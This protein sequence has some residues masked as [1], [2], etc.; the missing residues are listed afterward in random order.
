MSKLIGTDPNQVPSNAD[1]GTAAFMDATDFL[2]SRGSSLSAVNTVIP[3]TAVDVFV[4][5]TSR[6]SDGGAWRKRTKNTS[7]YNERLNTTTR[8]SR[9]EFPA[10]AVIVAE[11]NQVTIYDGDD[12]DMPMWMVFE[13]GA[14]TIPWTSTV[15][16]V[17]FLNGLFCI[18]CNGREVEANFISEDITLR[19]ATY[20]YAYLVNIKGRNDV[21]S[22][23]P[24]LS[25]TKNIINSTVNDLAMTVLPNAPIDSATG[26]PVPTIAVATAGGVSVI[27]DTGSVYDI[28]NSSSTYTASYHVSF[29]SKNNLWFHQGKT[30]LSYHGWVYVYSMPLSGDTAISIN[31][32]VATGQNPIALFQR[33]GSGGGSIEFNLTGGDSLIANT[34]IGNDKG[35]GV[36]DLNTE[37]HNASMAFQSTSDFNTGWQVGDIKLATL[38]DTDDTDIVSTNLVTGDNSTFTGGLGDWYDNSYAGNGSVLTNTGGHLTMNTNGTYQQAFVT[39]TNV[40]EIGKRYVFSWDQIAQGSGNFR[41]FMYTDTLTVPQGS[42]GTFGMTFVATGV[43]L[44]MKFKRTATSGNC[45][46]DNI[47]VSLAEADRSV[48]GNGLQVF[49]TVTKNPVAT[50]ADLMAYSG[51]STT[52]SKVNYLR[53]PYASALDFDTSFCFM[54]WIKIDGAV[55]TQDQHFFDMINDDNGNRVNVFYQHST[56]NF[57]MAPGNGGSNIGSAAVQ[58]GQW[59]HVVALANTATTDIYVNGELSGTGAGGFNHTWPNGYVTLGTRFAEY[60]SSAYGLN[61]SM[62]LIR[63]SKSTPS[64]EQ[65]KKIYND[66]KHLFQE[67]AKATLYGSSDAV[68]ALAYDDS[69][70]LLHV[71]TSN[72]RSDFQG[73][74][75][76]NN[77][78]RA[79][80]A[81]ISAADGFIIEE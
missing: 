45:Q 5:D 51:F 4:Y 32:Q 29:D 81:V 36:F 21:P 19:D 61:G 55:G 35:I 20:W 10:V 62:A 67:N 48:N 33:I 64:S 72:G 54:G 25:T 76:V 77:T 31:S 1:L 71:G 34:A 57:Y 26:L 43:D 65:I 39:L 56:T 14:N 3:K 44:T 40:L 23:T 59:Y 60:S 75:R 63:L 73:L 18:G 69:T 22:N 79:V 8:G 30:L 24:I 15:A 80:G 68:T 28:T 6:D 38:S 27:S 9:K 16:R 47:R 66:E 13:T 49:G 46:V 78:T 42:T 2:T 41:A 37:N 53:M 58:F 74:T 7:W 52:G 70:E 11:S 50:G 12:P 17:Y